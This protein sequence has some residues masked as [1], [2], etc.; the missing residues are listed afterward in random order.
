MKTTKLFALTLCLLLSFWASPVTAQSD[1]GSI[2]GT[3]TDPSGAAIS[4]AKI[5]A[6][7]LETGETRDTTTGDEGNYTLPEL[8][9]GPYKLTAEL[10]G[11]KLSTIE[12]L[13]V[14]VQV[15][16]R[17]DIQL[18][19]G[20]VTDVVTVT[21][22]APVIQAENAV[23]QTNVTE[24]QVKELPLAVGAETA[25]RTPL[26]FIF[27]DSNVSSA[28]GSTGRGTDASNFRV[29]GGQGLGTDILIDGASTRRAQNG[30]FFTEVAPGPNAFQEFTISTSTYSAEFGSST[31]GIVNFTIKSGGNEFHGEAYDLFRNEALNANSFLN[32]FQGFPTPLDRQNNF[33]AN[34]GGPVWIPKVYN[35]RDRT[36]FFFNYEGYRF[37]RGENVVVSVPTLRMRQGDFSELLTDPDVLRQFPNGVQIYD[38]TQPA[39]VR[40]AIPGNRLDLFQGGALIDPAGLAIL[41]RFPEPTSEGVF[42]NYVA[43]SQVPIDMNSFVTKIDQ[44]ITGSQRLSFSYSY[45]KQAS[46]KGGFPRFPLPFI[47]QDVWDQT[48][49][50]HY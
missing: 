23:R 32:N 39:S 33:G 43:S 38:P 1:R 41:Q 31:G 15:T 27:L 12:D 45:R 20:N 3:V 44:V 11:F 40:Q 35:G 5:T 6:T 8:K 4:G 24:R 17:V 16:R 42:R 9:A 30:T 13:Q 28:T 25:G 10:Q 2:T 37:T 49:R 29:S 18:E 36:F 47:Q 50:S 14:A 26:S 21:T 48:F 22:D 7:N 19:V 34:I 46:L